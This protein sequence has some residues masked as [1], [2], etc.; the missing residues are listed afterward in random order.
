MRDFGICGRIRTDARGT[1]KEQGLYRVIQFC[2]LQTKTEY[3]LATN[4][5]T[6]GEAAIADV[7]VMEIY[8]S[9]GFSS[10][11]CQTNPR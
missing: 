11:S 4:L 2:D 3:R 6:A 8:R 9:R 10:H 1:G 5:P 7:E